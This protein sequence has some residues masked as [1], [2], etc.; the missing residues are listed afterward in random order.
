MAS[1]W[2]RENKSDIIRHHF[3]QLCKILNT[4]STTMITLAGK[5]YAKRIIDMST[6]SEILATRGL[7]SANLLMDLVMIKIDQRPER[8]EAV[9]LIME[10]LEDLQDILKQIRK[11]Q[12]EIK[13]TPLSMYFQVLQFVFLR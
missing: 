1:E 10:E 5:L 3:D 13:E 2:R 11:E 4:S 7:E 8:L 9:L 12:Y 6:K